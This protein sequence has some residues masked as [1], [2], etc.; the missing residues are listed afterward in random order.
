MEAFYNWYIDVRERKEP[1]PKRRNQFRPSVVAHSFGTYIVGHALRTFEDMSLGKIVLCGSIL[2]RDFD[3]VSIFA[4]NQVIE[5]RNDYGVDDMWSRVTRR[6]VKETGS[7][8]ANGFSMTSP[9]VQNRRFEYFGHSDYFRRGHYEQW[10]KFLE[11]PLVRFRT[12]RSSDLPKGVTW[13][14]IVHY[15]RIIDKLVYGQLE[16]YGDVAIPNGLSGRWLGINPDIYTLLMDQTHRVHGYLN[17]M[18]LKAEVFDEVLSG[19]R[20]DDNIKPTD[21]VTYTDGTEIDLY[22][23]SIAIHPESRHLCEGVD[24][25][26]LHRLMYGLIHRLEVLAREH[27]VFVKRLGAVGWTDEGRRLCEI[28]GMREH[29]AD[30]FKHPAYLLDFSEPSHGVPPHRLIRNLQNVYSELRGRRE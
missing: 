7:S 6:I 22:L 18:P 17:A 2:P 1:N 14:N 16:H 10:I 29:G 25:S 15:S 24:Q 23:M 9:L 21:I 30:R 4:R 28:L 20:T 11:E 13:D 3:W 8:G 5:V 26:G 19:L 12:V 27:R